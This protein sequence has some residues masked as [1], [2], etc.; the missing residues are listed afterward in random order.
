M[1]DE[2]GGWLVSS[3]PHLLTVAAAILQSKL[4]RDRKP[5]LGEGAPGGPRGPEAGT[6]AILAGERT[7]LHRVPSLPPTRGPGKP[8][9]TTWVSGARGLGAFWGT[10]I[11]LEVLQ[12]LVARKSGRVRRE[13]EPRVPGKACFRCRSTARACSLNTQTERRGAIAMVTGVPATELNG[14]CL[15]ILGVGVWDRPL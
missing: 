6:S 3:Q 12:S 13:G 5:A 4:G 14:C 7:T 15:A 2:V 8:L 9:P 1:K 11:T 10:G